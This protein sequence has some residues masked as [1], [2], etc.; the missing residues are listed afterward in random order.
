MRQGD[1]QVPRKPMSGNPCRLASLTLKGLQRMTAMTFLNGWVRAKAVA[2]CVAVVVAVALHAGLAVA[3]TAA[4]AT[5]GAPAIPPAVNLPYPGTIT[6]EVDLTDLDRKIMQVRETLPV[7]P[8][9]LTLLYPRWIPGTHS[10][11]GSVSRMA[12]L[13]ITANGKL[14]EWQR[15]TLDVHAFHLTVPSGVDTLKLAFQHLSPVSQSTGRVVMTSEIIGLQ[16]NTVVLYPAGHFVSGIQVQPWAKLP[17][18]WQTGTAL[19]LVRRDGD[20]FEFKPVSLE[21]LVDSP[22]WAGKHTRRI[23]LDG[24]GSAPVFLNLFADSPAQLEA[25]PEHIA[26]H[27][28]LVKQA[29][30][31]FGSRH[32]ARYEFLLAISEQ[33]S[34]IGLEHSESSENAVRPGYFTEWKKGS[35]GR[36]L[37]PHEYAHSWNGKFRR[38]VDLLTPNF[39]LPMQDSLLWIYEG[40]TQ[41]WGHVLAARSGIVP[42][43]DSLNSLAQTAASLDTRSGR[44]WRNLQDTTNEPIVNQRGQMDWPDWQRREEYYDEGLLIWLDA[45]IKVRELTADS[46]SLADVARLFFGIEDGRVAAVPYT[47]DDYVKSLNAVAASSASSVPGAPAATGAFDWAGFLRQRLDTN[48]NAMLLGGISRGGW[49][50]VFSEQQSDY[51]KAVEAEYKFTGFEHSLGFN[52]DKDAK[53]NR[54]KWDGPA[55]KAGL[56]SN[57]QLIAVN[58]LA[59]KADDLRAAI[60]KAKDGSGI[61]L[62]VKVDNRYKTVKIDYRG[63]LR[64]PKLERI[65]GTVDRLTQVLSAV[66]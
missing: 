24:R 66:K 1:S 56:T 48:S 45:D 34:L 13:Q 22:L 3:Q 40:Q 8:G 20:W 58:S 19:D 33:F 39:N 62:L 44:I 2:T 16:W 60:A 53:L 49:R 37:L 54:I 14:L 35:A 47:F 51:S 10:P 52:L 6:V 7:K 15:D 50:L 41:Y 65:E 59:Y 9:P 28:E 11:T 26:A 17:N 63:G 21:T 29:D 36:T 55:F 57:T 31:V 32:F 30:T 4:V 64:Y 43:L 27:K 42:L 38:P 61:E 18:G 12:G 5:A 46:K 23:E 25:L